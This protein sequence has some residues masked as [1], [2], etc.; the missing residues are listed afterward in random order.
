M[1]R[2]LRPRPRRIRLAL[3]LVPSARSSCLLGIHNKQRRHAVHTPGDSGG[4]S[5]DQTA[6]VSARKSGSACWRVLRWR[7]RRKTPDTHD[8]LRR[9][10]NRKREQRKASRRGVRPGL[11]TGNK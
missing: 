6:G 7:I 5:R 1:A 8:M 10:K 11:D 2:N 4:R 9:G 3:S